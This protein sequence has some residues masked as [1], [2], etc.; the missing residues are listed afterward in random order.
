MLNNINNISL[1]AYIF[2]HLQKSWLK[3]FWYKKKQHFFDN[4]NLLKKLNDFQHF[5]LKREISEK[6]KVK[7]PLKLLKITQLEQKGKRTDAIKSY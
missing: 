4:T 1:K 2:M 3:I 7:I 6:G 5:L